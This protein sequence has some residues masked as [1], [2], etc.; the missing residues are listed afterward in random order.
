MSVA[1][2]RQI[3]LNVNVLDFG[4]ARAAGQFSGLPASLVTSADYYAGIGRIAERGKL[5]AVFL[6]DNPSLARNPRGRG[7]RAL[8]PSIILTAVAEATSHIGLIGT[9]STTYNDPVE[10][11]ERILSLDFVSGGRA[12][13]NA[14]T[15]YSPAAG[16]NFG[17]TSNPD[18]A[19]RYRRANEFVDVVVGLWESAVTG[20]NL[21]HR[22]E[23]FHVEG[24][25]SL[26]ESPQGHP[27]VVQAGGS[28]QGRKLAGRT[29]N[30]V[31]TAE[32]VLKTAIEHYELVKT[33]AI[34]H[35]RGREDVAILPGLVTTLGSTQAEAKARDARLRELAPS[36]SALEMLSKRLDFD[37]S[38]LD[39]DDRIPPEALADLRD[40]QAFKDSL[41]FREAVVEVLRER[42][43]TV[44]EAIAKFGGGGHNRI[45]GTP[46]EVADFIETWF[47]AGAAD[48]F[49]LMPD[50][51]P[52]GLDDFVDQVVPILRARGLFRHEYA[53]TTLRQR[54]GVGLTAERNARSLAANA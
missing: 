44:R 25:L 12:A 41:G 15:T 16:P 49:N 54:W 24:R 6:A 36:D 18:R 22:G 5:D 27:L 26:G 40:P 3:I 7:S 14:V 20:A 33:E 37:F 35:G 19:T 48:G 9:L 43:Y 10:L 4:I 2:S 30:G 47:R 17:L 51:F 53:E 46:E 50:A 32:F 52:S 29:A 11:A 38:Q 23:F 13:W 31:F 21:H 1:Q 45:V 39:L 42:P 34:A 8:E 28:P